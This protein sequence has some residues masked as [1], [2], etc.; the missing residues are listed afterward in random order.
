MAN[1]IDYYKYWTEDAIKADLDTKRHNF[2]LLCANIVG[3]FNL[4]TIIR[5]AN[6]FLAK[7]VIIYGRKQYDRRGTVGTHRYENLKHV[8]TV[9]ELDELKA[10]YLNG[11]YL[12]GIDNIPAAK[13][14]ET[15]VWPKDRH[16]VLCLGEEQSGIPEEIKLLCDEFV[17]IQQYG[18]VRSLNVGVAAGIAVYDLIRKTV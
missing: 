13:P 15:F 5:C 16:I 1:V 3:D 14:I 12:V 17:Y 10:N 7:E 18:S 6:A 9:L 11:S 4:G 2:S 8:R